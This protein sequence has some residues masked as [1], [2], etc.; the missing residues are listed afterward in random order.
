MLGRFL[1][2]SVAAPDVAESLSFY[3]SLGFVQALVGDIW[4]HPYAVVTDGRLVLGLHQQETFPPGLTWMHPDLADHRQT[5]LHAGIELQSATLDDDSFHQI[6]F[7][8]PTGLPINLI[9]ARTF[10]PATVA[11]TF[12]SGLGYFEEF[13]IPTRDPVGC[14]EFWERLGLVA[15]EPEWKPF[16]KVPVTARDISIAL[17]DIDLRRPVMSFSVAQL[18]E[19]VAGFRD[20]GYRFAALPDG[21]S[22]AAS[23]LLEAPEGSLLLLTEESQ[24]L[25]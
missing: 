12:S 3:E 7:L 4:S 2:V 23:A 1:E 16:K 20:R 24:D 8:D 25:N 5:L 6:G 13:G 19:R 9:E 17:Y 14:A 11:A 18:A 22:P 15:F 21:L 10:T